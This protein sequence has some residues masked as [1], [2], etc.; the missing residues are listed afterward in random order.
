M[1]RRLF[2][3]YSWRIPYKGDPCKGYTKPRVFPFPSLLPRMH[4]LPVLDDENVYIPRSKRR[5]Y[6][7]QETVL[8]LAEQLDLVPLS[9]LIDRPLS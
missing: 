8:D 3:I 5:F 1:D 2:A 9:Y 6:A 7:P 4:L